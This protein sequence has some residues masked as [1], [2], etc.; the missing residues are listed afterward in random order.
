MDFFSSAT[1]RL[2]FMAA[3]E[4]S[5]SVKCSTDFTVSLRVNSKNPGNH[6]T[7]HPA[8]S[9]GQNISFPNMLVEDYGERRTL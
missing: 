9:S 7:F 8:P 1:M 6:L 3:G 2:T 4:T 5:L